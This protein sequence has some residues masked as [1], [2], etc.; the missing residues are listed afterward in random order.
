[1]R[2]PI[3][4]ISRLSIINLLS[5]PSSLAGKIDITLI[6]SG[7]NCKNRITIKR[8]YQCQ[9]DRAAFKAGSAGHF[10]LT[11]TGK[12]HRDAVG[13]VDASLLAINVLAESALDHSSPAV[14]IDD[15]KI[16]I[17]LFLHFI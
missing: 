2:L 7:K 6:G 13:F 10:H 3:I 9:A 4:K 1:M 5:G 16:A 11:H 14:F 15:F 17:D 8:R 12:S